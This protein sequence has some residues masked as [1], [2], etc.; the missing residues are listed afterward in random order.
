MNA[1]ITRDQVTFSLGNL[2]YID[3]SYD[4]QLPE[5]A[6]P[7]KRSIFARL[8]EWRQRRRLAGEL[9][10][11]TDRELADIGLS[12]VDLSRVLDPAFATDHARGRGYIAF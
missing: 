6:A 10:L 2:S 8:R 11:M 4:E 9:A 7:S 12:R 3:S 1:P 5:P